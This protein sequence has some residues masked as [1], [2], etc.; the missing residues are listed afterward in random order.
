MD[1]AKALIYLPQVMIVGSKIP[2][3]KFHREMLK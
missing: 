3:F 2:V 1:G